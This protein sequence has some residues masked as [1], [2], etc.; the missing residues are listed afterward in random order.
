MSRTYRPW[1]S[2]LLSF[3]LRPASRNILTSLR[4]GETELERVKGRERVR[5]NW[6]ERIR[7]NGEGYREESK[8]GGE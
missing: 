6:R 5:E 2:D 8:R 3:L 4:E 1:S 7:A